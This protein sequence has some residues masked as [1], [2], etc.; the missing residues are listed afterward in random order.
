MQLFATN[1]FKPQ[2]FNADYFRALQGEPVEEVKSGVNRLYAVML[3]EEADRAREEEKKKPDLTPVGKTS[4]SGEKRVR[5]VE[6]VP[7]PPVTDEKPP[8]RLKPIFQT[9]K[10]EQ[11]HLLSVSNL[12][13]IW[14]DEPNIA[15][16]LKLSLDL[17]LR[18]R[19][20]DQNLALL[21]LLAA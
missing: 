15:S 5:K 13:I 18:K 4:D 19:E 16:A 11:P 10:K 8:A 2:Y 1:H 6:K 21:L 7:P 14:A 17:K 12:D 20:Y 9:K 3:Q